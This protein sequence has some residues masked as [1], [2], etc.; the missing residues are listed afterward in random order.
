ME[1]GSEIGGD[2]E[3]GNTEEKRLRLKRRGESGNNFGEK[4][5]NEDQFLKT[6]RRKNRKDKLVMVKTAK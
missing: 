4:S 2:G 3:K 1:E 6:E 5:D